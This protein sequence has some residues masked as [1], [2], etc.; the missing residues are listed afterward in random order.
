MRR[1]I[2]LKD[3]FSGVSHLCGA[4]LGIAALVALLV[5]A[6]G[7]PWH[8]SA[9]AIYGASLIVLYTASALYH[10]LPVPP[11][12]TR[13]LQIFDHVGIYLMIA[14]TY[15]PVCLIPLRGGWGWSLFG[16]VWG[17]AVAGIAI[18]LGWRTAPRWLGLSLYLVMGWLALV[19]I[20]PLS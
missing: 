5:L 13:R 9:F 7:K 19:A 3:P 17:I 2:R 12:C 8:L 20:A 6:R 14:G 18:R 1:S 4:L 15:T 16:V 10:L 11:Q